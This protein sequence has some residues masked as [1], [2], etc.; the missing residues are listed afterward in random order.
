[1]KRVLEVRGDGGTGWSMGWK[2]NFWARLRDGNRAGLLLHNQLANQD[3]GFD[4]TMI[5]LFS[6]HPPFQ[7]DGNFGATSGMTE[8]LLQSQGGM[9]EVLPALPDKWADGSFHG[10]KARGNFEVTAEWANGK[11]TGVSVVSGSGIDCVLRGTGIAALGLKNA[12]GGDVPFTVIDDNTISFSTEPG[13][14]YLLGEID[15]SEPPPPESEDTPPSVPDGIPDENRFP[16]WPVI[17]GGAVLAAG[18]AIAAFVI[19][20]KK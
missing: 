4:S 19:K 1:M 11:P 2:I 10:L 12:S 3:P 20:R 7:I 15:I 18:T 8:M 9:V 17:I 5:N 13:G 14:V 6:S 16:I